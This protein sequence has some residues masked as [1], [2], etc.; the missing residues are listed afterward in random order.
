M[1]SSF[2]IDGLDSFEHFGMIVTEGGYNDLVVYAPTKEVNIS[3]YKEV[4]GITADLSNVCLKNK[5]VNIRFGILGSIDKYRNFIKKISDKAYH[6]FGFMQIG[7]TEKLR[8]VSES[9]FSYNG[10][11]TLATVQFSDDFPKKWYSETWMIPTEIKPFVPISNLEINDINI[12]CYGLRN[13]SGALDSI[14]RTPK[15]KAGT[16]IE[17][18]IMDSVFYDNTDIKLEGKEISINLLMKARDMAEFWEQYREFQRLLC[19]YGAKKLYHADLNST[20]WF[21]FK[22]CSVKEF[23]PIGKI[24]FTFSIT[25]QIL[26]YVMGGDTLLITE[27]STPETPSIYYNRKQSMY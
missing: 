15:A 5:L 14:L 2:L 9:S 1:Q 21:Y 19:T 27:E 13:L 3:N 12:A 7:L 8:Y 10:K 6:T 16:T 25:L 18:R 20:F 11:F 23:S 22:S 24:W 26:S 17:N 4:D